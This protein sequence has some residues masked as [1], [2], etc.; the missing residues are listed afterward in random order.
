MNAGE[1]D[2][3]RSVDETPSFGYNTSNMANDVAVEKVGTEAEHLPTPEAPRSHL[4]QLIDTE[5]QEAMQAL[6]DKEAQDALV[7]IK[8]LTDIASEDPALVQGSQELQQ[9]I[10]MKSEGLKADLAT[11]FRGKTE[12]EPPVE[13]IEAEGEVVEG[14]KSEKP[15]RLL[16]RASLKQKAEESRVRVAPVAAAAGEQVATA[17]KPEAAAAGAVLAAESAV[18]ATEGPADVEGDHRLI[19][20]LNEEAESAFAAGDEERMKLA[21]GNT[22]ERM[23]GQIASR[24]E[25]LDELYALPSGERTE[26]M[27]AQIDQLEYANAIDRKTL[28]LRRVQ[29]EI[30]ELKKEQ[31]QVA[32]AITALEQK[33]SAATEAEKPGLEGDL[34]EV[35][36]QREEVGGKISEKEGQAA[37]LADTI[38]QLT[39]LMERAKQDQQ[40]LEGEEGAEEKE[41]TEEAE[42]E[43]HREEHST[44]ETGSGNAPDTAAPSLEKMLA[45][46]DKIIGGIGQIMHGDLAPLGVVIEKAKE[47][48]EIKEEPK[49]K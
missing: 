38:L 4:D 22:E 35:K 42:A 45:P 14:P 28:E 27:Q 7:E 9:Q 41:E 37:E 31:T 43:G 25:K 39:R 13:V 19:G 11:V 24:T 20:K 12:H 6:A 3:P 36:A 33:I 47:A 21:V 40:R 1:I 18:S 10:L 16:E 17:S 26:S 2:N 48:T 23:K 32:T 5:N 34:A 15:S 30:I 46:G 8:Q 44:A 29:L 49:K